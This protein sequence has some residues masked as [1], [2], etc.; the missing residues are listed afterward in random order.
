MDKKTALRTYKRL[1]TSIVKEYQ[2]ADK[3][4]WYNTDDPDLFPIRTELPECPDWNRIENFGIPKEKQVFQYEEIP[5]TLTYLVDKIDLEVT[6]DKSLTS[7][8]KREEYF[9]ERIWDELESS[10]KYK[11]LV[12][13]IEEQWYY[14]LHG[15]WVF[16]NGKPTYIPKNQWFYLNYWT[17][18]EVEGGRPSYRERDREWFWAMQYFKDYKKI[19]KVDVE[20]D[21]DGTE[22]IQYYYNDDGSLKLT[23]VGHRT[24]EGV[25][26]AKGRRAGDTTKA[27]CDIFCDTV[28]KVDAK[29]GIQGNDED[30]GEQVFNQKLMY[31][32]DRLPFFWKPKRDTNIR[33]AL[34]FKSRNIKETLNV[35]IDYKS[36]SPNGYDGRKL[37][38]YYADEP[39]K[40][41]KYSV[42][43]RHSIVRLCL[44]LGSRVNGFSIYTTTVSDMSSES[45]KNFEKLCKD[46]FY[47]ERTEDGTT[48]SGMVFIHFPADHGQEGFV[49]RYGES[50]REK[51]TEEQLKYIDKVQN[52][53]GDYIGAREFIMMKRDA[54]RKAGEPEKVAEI[55]R[56]L[57]LT[58]AESFAPP[59]KNIFF[60]IDIL[61]ERINELKRDN[62]ATVRGDFVG[63][64]ETGVRFEL[65]PTGGRFIVSD[66]PPAAQ[67]NRKFRQNGVWYPQNTGAYVSSADPYRLE[68][69]Q[70]YQMSMGSFAVKRVHDPVIDPDTKP[71]EEWSTG[72]IACTYLNRPE[73]LYEYNMDILRACVYYGCL[74]F[75][76]MNI[77]SL[78]N[79]FQDQSWGGYLMYST[80]PETGK[81]KTN[82]GFHSGSD[83]KKMLFNKTRD[84]IAVFGRRDKHI[85][86]LMDCLEIRGLEDMT[87]HDL[88]VSC[89]G[90][91]V[92][93]ES[94]YGE[95]LQETDTIDLKDIL[96]W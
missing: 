84:Y 68:K 15:K 14:R 76:E 83:M 54:F 12:E 78:A 50:V 29:C 56:L 94:Q 75:P 95:Y 49:G 89:A 58:F 6:A 31:A 60:N 11:K 71:I 36:A 67:S 30:T 7:E 62:T 59:A 61:E 92:A 27:T 86:Y 20:V 37:F 64:P 44:K 45:G 72:L 91:H 3:Y 26:V 21:D 79:F 23:D 33:S 32:Y 17:L 38:R 74:L 57:P 73:T 69:T 2:D 1:N 53:N 52:Y 96:G 41:E 8:Q 5:S 42:D 40:I 70:G 43:E 22:H 81:P 90:C 39:G 34:V 77:P 24:I 9:Y 18:E 66:L 63:N 4:Q 35:K 93:E 51:P 46:S 25:I 87:K 80:D 47:N 13:W 82:P 88:F 10:I 85:E 28:L 55:K 19:P 16:I 48:R 65:N